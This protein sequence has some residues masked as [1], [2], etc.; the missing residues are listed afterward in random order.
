MHIAVVVDEHGGTAGIV[1]FEDLIEEIVGPIRDEYD[2]A[3]QE[4][5][6]IR[7]RP[8]G[9]GQRSLPGRRRGRAA[10]SRHRRDRRRLHRRPG[11]RA[12]RGDPQG[13]GGAG[14]GDGDPHRRARC[15]G[16]ASRRCG[17][18]APSPSSSSATAPS[19]PRRPTTQQSRPSR[20]AHDAAAGA[21]PRAAA[22][23]D[24]RAELH[25][26]GD[27]AAPGQLRRGRPHPHRAHPR[28][29]QDGG[30][31]PRACASRGAGWRPR[32]TSSSAAACS[33][34]R[35]GGSCWCSPRPSAL[36]PAARVRRRSAPGRL[37]RAWSPSS[38]IGC[39][40]ATIPTPRSTSW[41]RRRST[42]WADPQRDPRRALVWFAR[43][44]IDRLGYAPQLQRCVSCSGRLAEAPA[45]FSAAGG[46]LLCPRL[47]SRRPGGDRLPRARD[48]GAPGGGRRRRRHLGPA[49]SRPP[50]PW[51]PSRRIIE[52]ELAHHLD[53][54]LRSWE[55]LR[56]LER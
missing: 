8:R 50:R 33:S 48:Q 12:T 46:G 21:R 42:S 26:R 47:P 29:R 30:D 40:R 36:G 38:P 55:V 39:S 15:G 41:S 34:P 6:Q 49:P 25:R 27:R 1:T 53:R 44:M 10:P 20:D 43:Q 37:R 22:L 23:H 24:G 54:R 51:P 35:A 5:V 11:L 4:D 52:A 19:A 13:G 16:R 17:S 3:E 7:E 56:A 9:G 2:V 18:S 28:A 32:P 45:A 14:P 31:R